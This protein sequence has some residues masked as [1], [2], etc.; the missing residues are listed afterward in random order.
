MEDKVTL[1]DVIKKVWDNGSCELF[2]MID[3]TVDVGDEQSLYIDELSRFLKAEA[4]RQGFT[5]ILYPKL[6]EPNESW[7]ITYNTTRHCS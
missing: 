4:D 7:V 1:S 3:Q 5:L 6:G 2:R